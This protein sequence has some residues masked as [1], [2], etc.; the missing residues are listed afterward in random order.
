MTLEDNRRANEE[1]D[2]RA[3]A[4]GGRRDGDQKKPWY[5]R[6]R[7]WLAAAS[8]VFMGWK[9]I[10]VRSKKRLTNAGRSGIAA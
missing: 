2:R 4:R 5:L 1:R 8:L 7:L 10:I 9:R 3:H 6:R